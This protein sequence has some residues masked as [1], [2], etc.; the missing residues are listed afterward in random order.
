MRRGEATKPTLYYYFG[1]KRNLIFSL[2]YDHLTKILQPY[3]EA[4]EYTGPI[5]AVCLYDQDL[6]ENDL[7]PPRVAFPHTR[8]PWVQGQILQPYQKRM[9]EPLSASKQNN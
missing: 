6:H 5:G 3:L 9:E 4:A 1:S 7:H 8:N 2:H